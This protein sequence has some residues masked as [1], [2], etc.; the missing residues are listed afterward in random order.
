LQLNFE[1][2]NVKNT[3]REQTN[4]SPILVQTI[5]CDV[6]DFHALSHAFSKH[7]MDYG[8]MDVVVSMSS[9]ICTSQLDFLLISCY[10][11]EGE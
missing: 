11:D 6:T 2:N 10:V 5:L 3:R 8:G 9:R 1:A 7:A 4:S